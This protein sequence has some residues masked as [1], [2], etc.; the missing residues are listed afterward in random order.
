MT[1]RWAGLIGT[2]MAQSNSRVPISITS[3]LCRL[4]FPEFILLRGSARLE[5]RI[6]K[7]SYNCRLKR[8]IRL[9][10]ERGSHGRVWRGWKRDEGRA[11]RES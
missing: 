10:S 5:H 6:L 1:A 2:I 3:F 9:I 4:E 7:K 8:E 11:K